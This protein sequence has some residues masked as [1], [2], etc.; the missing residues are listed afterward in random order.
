ML[1]DREGHRKLLSNREGRVDDESILS[2]YF[3]DIEILNNTASAQR[4][5]VGT[6]IK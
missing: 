1:F 5:A 6:E 3:P 2:L 4:L